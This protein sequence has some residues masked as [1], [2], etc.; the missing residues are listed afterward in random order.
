MFIP[1][2]FKDRIIK[3]GFKIS[4]DSHHINHDNSI[5][6]ITSNYP[7]FGIEARYINKIMNELSIVYARIINQDIFK[8]QTVF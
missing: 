4:L 7:E 3:V 5:L 2:Y 1:Y 6:T 8:Y